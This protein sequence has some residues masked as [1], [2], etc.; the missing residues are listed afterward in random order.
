MKFCP[1]CGAQLD[2]TDKFCTRCG[3]DVRNIT[4]SQINP[5]PTTRV[6]HTVPQNKNRGNFLNNKFK[7]IIIAVAVIC[8]IGRFGFYKYRTSP[9][10]NPNNPLSNQT[11]TFTK[12]EDETY[13]SKDSFNKI[14]DNIVIKCMKSYHFSPKVVQ[15]VKKFNIIKGMEDSDYEYD[16]E[17]KLYKD[18]TASD[19]KE[20][21]IF[22]NDIKKLGRGISGELVIVSPDK[23]LK[24]GEKVT[25]TLNINKKIAKKYGID[26]TPRVVKVTGLDN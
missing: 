18:S 23:N 24:N 2:D 17:E 1:N 21:Q 8:A 16:L 20:L 26:T 5:Q 14:E 7:Y 3:S 9:A 25:L 12:Y 6:E 13:L 4:S 22:G 19:K 11:I 10:H 15:D